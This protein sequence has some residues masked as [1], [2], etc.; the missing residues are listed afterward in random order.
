MAKLQKKKNHIYYFLLLQIFF[1]TF[2]SSTLAVHSSGYINETFSYSGL[3][4]A[5]RFGR[6]CRL[7]FNLINKTDKVFDKPFCVTIKG[8]DV[9]GN[10]VWEVKKC[11]DSMDRYEE[12]PLR[13]K[14]YDTKDCKSYE[15]TWKFTGLD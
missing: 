15:L 10:E 11:I 1:L 6:L 5:T 12:L 8:F 9:N 4:V 7:E 13:E 3:S 14:L 2:A